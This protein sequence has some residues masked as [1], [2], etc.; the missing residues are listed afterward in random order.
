M[1][2]SDDDRQRVVVALEKH[3]GA[4]RLTLDEFGERVGVVAQARTLGELAAVVSDLPG[5]SVVPVAG[6]ESHRELLW[7]FIVAIGAV[8]LL[9]IALA[10]R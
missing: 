5:E 9:A 2:A 7:V 8:L 6:P 4:G 3:T 10:L 1:R